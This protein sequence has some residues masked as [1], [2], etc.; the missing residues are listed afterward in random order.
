MA[1]CLFPLRKWGRKTFFYFLRG[2]WEGDR[3]SSGFLLGAGGNA[4]RV[5]LECSHWHPHHPSIP[6]GGV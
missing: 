2:I 3:A 6:L 1:F 5:L 4:L